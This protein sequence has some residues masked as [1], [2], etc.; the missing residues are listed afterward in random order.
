[1]YIVSEDGEFDY[2]IASADDCG[3]AVKGKIIDLFFDSL[4]ECYAFGRRDI[5]VYF[6]SE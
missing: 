4:E 1:M 5:T 3:G 2:G 6:L